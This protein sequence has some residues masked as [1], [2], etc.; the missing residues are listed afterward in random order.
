MK[1]GATLLPIMA[2]GNE[3]IVVSADKIQR[4]VMAIGGIAMAVI[5]IVLIVSVM[6]DTGGDILNGSKY[7]STFESIVTDIINAFNNI[8]TLLTVL[9]VIGI[10][11]GLV[12]VFGSL[13]VSMGLGGGR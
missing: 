9:T 12:W 6:G 7:K 10:V 11:L 8:P 2:A 5:M 13:R 1:I 3:D 4:L